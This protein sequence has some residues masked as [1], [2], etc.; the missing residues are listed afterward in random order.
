MKKLPM[1]PRV[2]HDEASPAIQM[3]SKRM[4]I[5]GAFPAEGGSLMMTHDGNF[6]PPSIKT[7]SSPPSIRQHSVADGF[8]N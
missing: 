7:I 6:P 5:D 2:N 8:F 1:E 3:S 4:P